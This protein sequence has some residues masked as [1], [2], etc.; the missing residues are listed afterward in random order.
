M[1]DA[2]AQQGA[3]T[4]AMVMEILNAIRA[5][6]VRVPIRGKDGRITQVIDGPQEESSEQRMN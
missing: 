5:P 1:L 6:R 2:I 3:Q 4:Q